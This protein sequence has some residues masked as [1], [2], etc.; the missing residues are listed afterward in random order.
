VIATN[1]F[2]CLRR[3]KIEMVF[4]GFARFMRNSMAQEPIVVVSCVIGAIG[5]F[6]K[7]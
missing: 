3:H 1:N 6:V 4:G 2:F 5:E 7:H